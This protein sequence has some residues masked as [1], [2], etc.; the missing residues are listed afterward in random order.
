MSRADVWRLVPVLAAFAALALF[1]LFGS[2]FYAQL[3]LKIMIF[4]IFAL[5][6]ELLVGQTGLVSLGH[7]AFFGIAAYVTVLMTKADITSLWLVLPAALFA[8]AAYAVAVGALSLRTKGIYFIM[9]TLAFAQMAY[10]VF[11]DTPVGGGSDGIYLMGAPVLQL[12]G[13]TLLDLGHGPTLYY[14][15]TGSAD[16]DLRLPRGD[17]AQPLRPRA[18]RHQGQRAA[19]A[20]GRLSHLR[21]QARRLRAVGGACRRGGLPVRGEGRPRQPRAAVVALQRRRC[22]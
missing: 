18:R 19:H 20:R 9:I 17:A 13:V 8:T 14:V 22:C 16:R 15:C 10:F 6:L 1:P 21:L 3:V 12:G 4:A 11:H 7:A 5:S 2:S